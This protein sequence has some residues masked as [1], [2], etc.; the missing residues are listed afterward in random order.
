MRLGLDHNSQFS[1]GQVHG[2]LSILWQSLKALNLLIDGINMVH[3]LFERLRLPEI[4]DAVTRRNGQALT[5][6]WCHR[7]HLV[8]LLQP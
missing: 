6:P 4:I 7:N 5:A 3:V 2:Q 8:H 1:A